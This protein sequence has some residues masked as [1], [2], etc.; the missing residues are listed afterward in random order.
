MGTKYDA[1][2]EAMLASPRFVYWHVTG[3]AMQGTG[4]RLWVR[5]YLS[6]PIDRSL[7]TK[8][9]QAFLEQETAKKLVPFT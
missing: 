3:F 8:E 6:K 7:L 1:G 2:F 4:S 5:G 9:L